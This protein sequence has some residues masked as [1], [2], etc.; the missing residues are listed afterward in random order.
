MLEK[1]EG[2]RLGKRI[3]SLGPSERKDSFSQQL[4]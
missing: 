4:L 3:T 1:R 2:K